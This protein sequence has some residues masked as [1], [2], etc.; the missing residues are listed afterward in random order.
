MYYATLPVC[1]AFFILCIITA[2]YSI[3][4]THWFRD[5]SPLY[6]ANFRQTMYTMFQVFTGDGWSDVTRT[7]FKDQDAQRKVV[8]MDVA[9]FFGS[10]CFISASLCLPVPVCV[11]I[12]VF[13]HQWFFVLKFVFIAVS[14]VFI[15]GIIL[16]NVVVA[17]VFETVCFCVREN[18]FGRH[19]V[20]SCSHATH[21]LPLPA[22]CLTVLLDEFIKFIAF[23]KDK[24][25]WTCVLFVSWS[26]LQ[27][28]VFANVFGVECMISLPW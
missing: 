4:G 28:C 1:N 17:G 6:F 7:L 21:A 26:F 12:F 24:G 20:C 14:Y 15:A 19:C 27:C 16:F 11:W 23:E 9:V 5:R 2:I 8:D 25:D 22:L 10:G 18:A 3:F 13:K